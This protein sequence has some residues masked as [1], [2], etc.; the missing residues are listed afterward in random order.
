MKSMK[1][2]YLNQKNLKSSFSYKTNKN[3]NNQVEIVEGVIEPVLIY[4]INKFMIFQMISLSIIK[5][6]SKI[7]ITII[8]IN[9]Q[10]QDQNKIQK[11]RAC[12]THFMIN[13]VINMD[14]NKVNKNQL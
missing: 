5:I 1:L 14:Q 8:N 3:C 11:Y 2:K 9:N 7:L 4:S 12:S 6:N 10:N 13:L